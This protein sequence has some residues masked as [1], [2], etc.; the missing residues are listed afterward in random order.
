M[1]LQCPICHVEFIR[2]VLQ[3]YEVQAR[4][5]RHNKMRV[6]GLQVLTCSN[7]HVFFIRK[8]DLCLHKGAAA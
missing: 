1:T 8:E 4:R 6:G 3:D 7:G 2:E 5:D